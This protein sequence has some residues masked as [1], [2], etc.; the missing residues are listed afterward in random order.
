LPIFSLN[1]SG[2]GNDPVIV[3]GRIISLVA[4]YIIHPLEIIYQPLHRDVI[5]GAGIRAQHIR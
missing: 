1:Q 2:L 4:V 3:V 5:K